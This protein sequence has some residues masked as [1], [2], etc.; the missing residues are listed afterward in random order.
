MNGTL[1]AG[2]TVA[3]WALGALYGAFLFEFRNQDRTLIELARR[4]R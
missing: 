1:L 2:Y 4:L 3:I